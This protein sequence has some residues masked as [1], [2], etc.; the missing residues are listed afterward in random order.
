MIPRG[1][2][3]VTGGGLTAGLSRSTRLALWWRRLRTR[4]EW[5]LRGERPPAGAMHGAGAIGEGLAEVHLARLGYRVLW[6]N[7]RIAGGEL[8]LVCEDPDGR[9]VVCIEVK[10]RVRDRSGPAR[11]REVAPERAV[12][13]AKRRRLRRAAK[14][15]MGRQGWRERPMRVDVVSVELSADGARPEI[16]VLTGVA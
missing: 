13:E 3:R 14:A 7:V 12:D 15:L 16:R 10:T 6:R 1:G 2:K 9:T 11:S 8:D 4:L 5:T